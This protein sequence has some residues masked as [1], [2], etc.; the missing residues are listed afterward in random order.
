M[1]ELWGLIYIHA[2]GAYALRGLLVSCE[3]KQVQPMLCGLNPQP[4]G[5]PV[6]TGL[7]ARL[8]ARLIVS[9]WQTALRVATE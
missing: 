9:G 8:K 6:R 7:L 5:I 1:L 4:L 2:S 3:Q